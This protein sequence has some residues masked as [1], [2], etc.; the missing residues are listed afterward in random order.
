MDL[1]IEDLSEKKRRLLDIL[2][3]NY[4]HDKAPRPIRPRPNASFAPLSFEQQ[5][6]WFLHQ[7]HMESHAYNML[8]GY[9]L[10]GRLNIKGLA[11][12][13]VE[14]VQRHEI[15]RTRFHVIDGEVRQVVDNV[16]SFVLSIVDLRELP[17]SS[18]YNVAL[19]ITKDE[20]RRTFDL[21]VGPILR[22]Y[23]VIVGKDYYI[24]LF[25]GHHITMDGMSL[26]ILTR[27]LRIFYQSYISGEA[28]PLAD[29]PIQYGDFAS[30]Q[31]ERLQEDAIEA[32]VR[33]WE[34][35]L[36][37]APAYL[38]LSVD[39]PRPLAQTFRGETKALAL[40]AGLS[41]SIR[42]LS[43]QE[44]TTLFITVLAIFKCLLFR[45][46]GQDDIVVGT[47]VAGR[48]QDELRNLIGLFINSLALRSKLFER[49]TFRD[50]L[51]A[52][53]LTA[54][55]AYSHREVPFEKVVERLKP[56]RQL[57]RAPI[58]Q[59][60]FISAIGAE[61]LQLPGLES[62]PLSIDNEN[63]KFDLTVTL[64]NSEDKIILLFEYNTDLYDPLTISCMQGN[65]QVMSEAIVGGADLPVGR[66]PMLA[67]SERYQVLCSWNATGRAFPGE[68]GVHHL[69][70][71]QVA[72]RPLATAVRDEEGEISYQHLNERANQLAHYLRRRGVGPEV[73][74]GICL[75][76]SCDLLVGLLGILKAGGA[77]LPLDPGY[78]AGRLVFM[79]DDAQVSVLVTQQ[80]LLDR[81]PAREEEVICLDRDWELIASA[82]NDNPYGGGAGANLAYVIYTSGSTGRPKGV[83]IS[84]SSAINFLKAMGAEPGLREGDVMLAITSLSFDIAVLELLLPL[85]VGGRIEL[86]SRQAKADAGELMAR[87]EA[88]AVSVMQ[89]T[90]V[91]YRMLLQAGWEGNRRLKVLCGGERLSRELAEEVAA[92]SGELWNMY[93]P[94]ESTIWSAAS[95][96]ET[97]A[98]V[99]T[100]GRPIA[101][102]QVYVL[103]EWMEPVPVGV[104]GE[105]YIG[106]AGVARGYLSRAELTSER[107]I[108]DLHGREIGGRL[109]RTGDLG[110]YLRDGR[111]ECLGRTD[112][113]IKV[114]GYRVELGE[115]ETA[116]REHVG[117]RDA[118]VTAHADATRGQR[119]V[120]YVV[121]REGESIRVG[122]LRQNLKERLPEYMIPSDYVVLQKLP[123]TPNGKLDRGAL[124][125]PETTRPEMAQ[126]VVLARTPLEA[127]SLCKSHC[128]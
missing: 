108:P 66:L 38:N 106:G 83:Q 120:G 15:L 6:V 11:K 98:E 30:W 3:Q 39:R 113:Q 81:L 64:R 19:N 20:A 103:D 55:A 90:P 35:Q 99:V 29:L 48:E 25:A 50:L 7:L 63:A 41:A 96:I 71:D 56:D 94:T 82:S 24:L 42:A 16:P 10:R 123:L 37:G 92:R 26:G 127:S 102:T 111:I 125:P 49:G 77:Y 69:F 78:P 122:D 109:Y 107:F 33:Y 80:S 76:R 9:H 46:T 115:I 72:I 45:Y 93:G 119:L 62:G 101:N 89:A 124:P 58:F 70:E 32:G 47:A 85:V 112:H 54:I 121:E 44:G 60:M 14:V 114:R 88:A 51:K 28:P 1:Q 31:R 53:R 12:S 27:E 67:E 97:G 75:E 84:H 59:V 86:V 8:G 74:V 34:Q 105:L 118:V 22:T 73:C 95:L 4:Q 5:R 2:L 18:R 23:L 91:T 104:V 128:G 43:A 57:D 100:I 52:V 61:G 65:L 68:R 40:S 79:L 13:F 36:A 87:L 116:L 126:T 110:R 21:T 17:E 117:V